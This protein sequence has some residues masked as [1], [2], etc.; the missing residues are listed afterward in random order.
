M[1][2]IL[3]K[4]SVFL[5]LVLLNSVG[6][7]QSNEIE[8]TFLGNAGFLMS[9]GVTNI[10]FDFPYK[11]GAYGYMTY[12]ESELD[13]IK[14]NSIFIFT[15]KHADHYSRKL[16]KKLKGEIYAGANR[17]RIDQLNKKLLD[18]KIQSFKTKHKFSL[19]H[20]SYLVDWKGK[21]FFISGDTE[22]P[23]TIGSIKNIDYVF[24]P[25]WILLYAKEA[26]L[27][28]DAKIRVLYHLYPNQQFDGDIPENYI[29]FNNPGMKFTIRVEYNS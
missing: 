20:Y 3:K 29:V 13:K 28:I 26:N 24:V 16:V 2:S 23:E 15:H 14:D 17:K 12:D 11:S 27:D 1:K 22:H 8:I 7:G 21:R 25:Y 18:F 4:F 19:T 9:D 6:F 5:M 10:Y